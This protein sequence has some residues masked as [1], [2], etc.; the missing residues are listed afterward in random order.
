MLTEIQTVIL[1]CLLGPEDKGA[2]A[3][4][5][6]RLKKKGYYWDNPQKMRDRANQERLKDVEGYRARRNKRRRELHPKKVSEWTPELLRAYHRNYDRS[7][8]SKRREYIRNRLRTNPEFRLRHYLRSRLWR[9]LLGVTKSAKTA[10]LLGCSIPELREHLEK[11][12]RPGMTWENYGPVWHVD[13][14]KPCAAFNLV[15]PE[16]QRI[17]FHWT[18]L[19]PLF[20]AENI[21]KGDKYAG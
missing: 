11:Q 16:Q 7:R 20:A 13:H 19:Q 12:F 15:D 17:C 21:A 14:I 4:E 5:Q 1:T 8:N 3:R 2:F 6:N 10:V 18:N 9:P